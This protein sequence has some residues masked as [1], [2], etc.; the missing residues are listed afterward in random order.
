[1][2]IVILSVTTMMVAPSFFSASSTS[3]HDE[4]KRLVQ[5]LRLA[6]DEAV[7]SSKILRISLRKQSYSVQS[8]SP[9]GEW[10]PFRSSPYQEYQ[11]SEGIHITQINPQPPLIEQT[12][13]EKEPVLAHLLF[14]PEGMNQIS[15]ITL[16]QSSSEEVLHIQFR[17][18]PGGIRIVKENGLE[19][20]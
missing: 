1:M 16:L 18:G 20:P 14:M 4:G 15:D 3:L 2:V 9:N 5:T 10:I 17:P 11:L 19:S 12:D 8:I 6:Q 13:E 7:L